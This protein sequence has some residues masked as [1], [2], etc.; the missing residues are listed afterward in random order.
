MKIT[1]I[2]FC[3][4]TLLGS[5]FAQSN[6][7]SLKETVDW[8]QSKSH[9]IT[10]VGA[11]T[12]RETVEATYRTTWDIHFKEPCMLEMNSNGWT[13]PPATDL[14]KPPR[15]SSKD[16][17]APGTVLPPGNPSSVFIP[18]S[19][20][21]PQKVTTAV[22]RGPFNQGRG[23]VTLVATDGK[24]TIPWRGADKHINVNSITIGFDEDG[25]TERV[26]KALV[27]AVNLCGGNTDK[28]EPF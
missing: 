7:V 25:L 11:K 27:H 2:F 1:F 15:V 14:N 9:F 8:L 18:L 12:Q 10:Y 23:N 21:N 4:L 3:V 22:M 5:S 19:G 6:D 17:L 28:K 16:I 13:P 24:E 20:I 26:A